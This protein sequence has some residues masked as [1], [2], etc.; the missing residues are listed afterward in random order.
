MHKLWHFY[1]SLDFLQLVPN[2]YR[3]YVT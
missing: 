2:V 1:M 3:A